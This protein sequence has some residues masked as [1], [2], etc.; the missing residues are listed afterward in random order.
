MKANLMKLRFRARQTQ[1]L[2]VQSNY[3]KCWVDPKGEIHL[4]D[5]YE[6]DTHLKAI[7]L[8]LGDHCDM[9]DA[10]KMGWLRLGLF[11]GITVVES[12]QW[13][14]SQLKFTKEFLLENP[15]W[16]GNLI[17]L[18]QTSIGDRGYVC[19]DFKP[20][21]FFEVSELREILRKRYAKR[22]A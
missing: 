15:D 20:Q 16:V 22:I 7:P 13:K 18:D 6:V 3:K 19:E 21:D 8:I 5:T 10:L 12:Y 14:D 9:Y 4:L 2:K 11:S 17:R 1:N